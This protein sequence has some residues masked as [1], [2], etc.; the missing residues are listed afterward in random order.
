MTEL[1][2]KTISSLDLSDSIKDVLIKSG[3][4][5]LHDVLEKSPEELMEIPGLT[6]AH[7]SEYKKYII[8]KGLQHLQ[9]DF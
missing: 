3:Y 4:N 5:Y 6:F 2:H 9:K 1:A 8:V 7:I